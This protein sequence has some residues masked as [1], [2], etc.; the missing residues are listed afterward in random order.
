[1][2]LLPDKPSQLI[3]DALEDLQQVERSNDYIVDMDKWHCPQPR[4]EDGEAPLEICCVCLAGAVMA[5]S[6]HSDPDSSLIPDH[7]LPDT[8]TRNKLFA[9]EY[10]RGG[11]WEDAL[12]EMKIDPP[13]ELLDALHDM[14]LYPADY[15]MNPDQFKKDLK[16]ASDILKEHDL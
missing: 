9:L 10:F 6:L 7:F 16:S 13:S 3:E 14:E 2:N 8:D 4:G 5:E 15:S 11:M 1:M 12:K